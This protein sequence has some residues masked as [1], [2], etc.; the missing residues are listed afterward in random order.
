MDYP[1]VLAALGTH[2][3]GRRQIKNKNKTQKTEKKSNKDSQKT[4]R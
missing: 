1:V 4:R 3:T 2:D